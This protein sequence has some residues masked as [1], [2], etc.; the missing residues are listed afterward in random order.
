MAKGNEK[1]YLRYPSPSGGWEHVEV[2]PGRVPKGT[3]LYAKDRVAQGVKFIPVSGVETSVSPN[4][5]ILRE[6]MQEML[7][8][9]SDA[10]AD[11]GDDGEAV[12]TQI[13]TP[14]DF[15]PFITAIEQSD[16]DAAETAL[17]E[18]FYGL[19]SGSC[20]LAKELSTVR[21]AANRHAETAR[22]LD[23]ALT[24]SE[25]VLLTL[26]IKWGAAAEEL[27]ASVERVKGFEGE[28]SVTAKNIRADRQ[29]WL[30]LVS[31]RNRTITDAVAILYDPNGNSDFLAVAYRLKDGQPVENASEQVALAQTAVDQCRGEEHKAKRLWQEAQTVAG[32]LVVE[33]PNEI[34]NICEELQMRMDKFRVARQQ[35]PSGAAKP[36]EVG[37]D[38]TG[39]GLVKRD[40]YERVERVVADHEWSRT[41]VFERLQALRDELLELTETAPRMDSDTL[42]T[43]E[44][45]EQALAELNPKTP[46]KVAEIPLFDKPVPNGDNPRRAAALK[47]A[48][49]R[50]AR[51]ALQSTT[52]N[53]L[54]SPMAVDLNRAQALY[55]IVQCIGYA[56]TCLDREHT[57]LAGSQ[58]PAMLDIAVKLGRAS[59]EEV[60]T[61]FAAVRELMLTDTT[62]VPDGVKL[63]VAWREAK[64][65]WL[66]YF[67]KRQRKDKPGAKPG[68]FSYVR[69]TPAFADDARQFLAKHTLDI[70]EIRR[71]RTA[72]AEARQLLYRAGGLKK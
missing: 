52:M 28:L 55:E 5:R 44:Q 14:F 2:D 13:I 37:Q 7:E 12:E 27:L 63:T 8:Q 4:G 62:L 20:A 25:D 18:I 19:M 1:R 42:S 65:R 56:T 3:A 31:N 48:A 59:A 51:K 41:A 50:A 45:A 6:I 54:S 17:R 10:L 16:T 47:A 67:V 71:V 58:L 43:I 49:T 33:R 24:N 64:S 21:Q 29:R 57:P 60:R 38:E 15:E 30:G 36:F 9:I 39:N 35:L 66:K 40:V 68:E 70:E 53:T 23:V 26:Y 32:Q 69:F 34:R 61:N 72:R 11:F 46:P 22:G